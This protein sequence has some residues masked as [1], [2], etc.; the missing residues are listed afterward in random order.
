MKTA[1][2]FPVVNADNIFSTLEKLGIRKWPRLEPPMSLEEYRRRGLNHDQKKEIL[3][4][5]PSIEVVRFR[6]PLSEEF[7]GFRPKWNFGSGTHV[8]ALLPNDLIPISAE[9]RHGAEVISLILPGGVAEPNETS[10]G[11]CAKREF[12]E[13]TGILLDSVEPLSLGKNNCIPLSSRQFGQRSC[14]FLGTLPSVLKI[15]EPKLDKQEFLKIVLIPVEEWLKL[16]EHGRVEEASPIFS[17]YMALRK[18][19]RLEFKG[20]C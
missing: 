8:F 15:L 18:L 1:F 13:E 14:G 20:G 5:T 11:L 7:V 17:T 3:K 10:L 16:I 6:D 4:F 19:G 12:E 2:G 9:F